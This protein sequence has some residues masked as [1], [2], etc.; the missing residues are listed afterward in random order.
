MT[1][2]IEQGT[3]LA[4]LLVLKAS[5]LKVQYVLWRRTEWSSSRLGGAWEAYTGGDDHTN[6]VHLEVSPE[7]TGA[8]GMARALAELDREIELKGGGL[9][10]VR[11]IVEGTATPSGP[12]AKTLKTAAAVVAAGV[13]VAL[14]T[15]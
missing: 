14:A 1:R 4:N 15:R 2:D 6:H 9:L 13:A 12:S 8:D 5:A 11:N 3:L 10:G 7:G